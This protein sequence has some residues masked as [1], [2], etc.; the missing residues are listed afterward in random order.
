MKY[1]TQQDDLQNKKEK[2][3]AIRTMLL[4]A[5]PCFAAAV[6]AF[7]LRIEPLCMA[8]TALTG[9]LLVFFADVKLMPAVRYGRLLSD[10]RCGSSHQTLG[11]LMR[12]SEDLTYENGV[13]FREV[14]INV[15]EDLSEEGER[16]F[17]LDSKKEM[18]ESFFGQDVVLTSYGN[19]ILE[20]QAYQP[21]SGREA[22]E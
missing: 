10:I 4:A 8:A 21:G 17:L 11:T 13:D 18:D 7:I 22:Q 5:A 3:A 15:Y 6:A 19:V 1:Y 16:R 2:N 14:I 12:V 9:C 20:A